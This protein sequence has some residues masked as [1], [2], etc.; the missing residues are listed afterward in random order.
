MSNTCIG[1]AYVQIIE[2]TE[3]IG[4]SLTK[5]NANFAEL[6]TQICG[7]N[8]FQ[9]VVSNIQGL[10]KVK[11]G[12]VVQAES[13]IDYFQPGT[14]LAAP[15]EVAGNVAA[16]GTLTIVGNAVLQQNVTIG[17]SSGT[18]LT[19]IK[20]KVTFQNPALAK[21]I[22]FIGN[23][24]NVGPLT[25]AAETL[26]IN[27]T[28]YNSGTTQ[29]RNL[30][31]CNGKQTSL[32]YVDSANSRVGVKT[33]SP[34]ATL[35]VA[36]DLKV[37]G[38]IISKAPLSLGMT[39]GLSNLS[40]EGATEGKIL[41]YSSGAVRWSTLSIPSSSIPQTAGGSRIAIYD[42][43]GTWSWTCPA[44]ITRITVELYGA[45]GG[46]SSSQLPYAPVA[47][48]TEANLS[49]MVSQAETRGGGGGGHAVFSIDVIPGTQYL[50]TVG[51]GGDGGVI[52][53]GWIRKYADYPY[54][55]RMIANSNFMGKPGG[56][57]L[58][59]I[60]GLAI[61]ANGGKGGGER[62]SLIIPRYGTIDNVH[63]GDG[64]SVPIISPYVG[65][66]V[67]GVYKYNSSSYGTGSG[68][69]YGG[70]SGG[71]IRGGG[72]GIFSCG[73][74]GGSPGSNPSLTGGAW[75]DT[76]WLLAPDVYDESADKMSRDGLKYGGGGG[77]ARRCEVTQYAN[78][79]AGFNPFSPDARALRGTLGFEN[80]SIGAIPYNRDFLY[81]PKPYYYGGRG[82]NGAV[83][84][85]F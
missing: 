43:P 71:A 25:N 61:R 51:E 77:P 56:D 64:G 4:N 84:I 5:I 15:L 63:G 76:V 31:V 10:L 20:G 17:S 83:I 80:E 11:E 21:N 42:T 19:D 41:T 79:S 32:L 75:N 68:G 7:L 69:G 53:D 2:R 38:A 58:I 55:A 82:A 12:Q 47:G 3:C 65:A 24:I 59:I 33:T 62:K 28:G 60:G 8:N 27:Y 72:S 26:L 52:P 29:F 14:T 9:E 73:G 81:V 35:H 50:L 23:Q 36:G 39:V 22:E 44:N 30:N 70:E 74:V 54:K 46:G 78:F 40:V 16:A 6:D 48:Q 66:G 18:T 85:H 37:D 13:G 67:G 57:T 45:G 1:N 49:A 34:D